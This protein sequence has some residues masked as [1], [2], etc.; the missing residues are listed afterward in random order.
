MSKSNSPANLQMVTNCPMCDFKYDGKK[1]IK[2]IDKKDGMVTFY[3][4]CSRC[5][6]SVIVTVMTEMFGI[7][8]IS[9]ITDVVEDDIKKIS[10]DFIKCDDV[11]EMHKFL[12]KK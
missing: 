6:S 4:N 8:S 5:K 10:G 3:L 12:E 2:M 9:M 11:L 7:T 1:N